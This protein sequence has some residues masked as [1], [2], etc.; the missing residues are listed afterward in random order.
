MSQIN[1]LAKANIEDIDRMVFEKFGGVEKFSRMYPSVHYLNVDQLRTIR[2]D[3]ARTTKPKSPDESKA[4]LEQMG[5]NVERLS[6]KNRAE[7]IG[8][9]LAETVMS[10]RVEFQPFEIPFIKIQIPLMKIELERRKRELEY[11]DKVKI[12]DKTNIHQIESKSNKNDIIEPTIYKTES[13]KNR[14]VGNN[15]HKGKH[16]HKGRGR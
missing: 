11:N 7:A 14:A 5:E 15:K 8:T 13:K 2:N 3:V 9:R 12:E 16:K 4:R 10:L 1:R 6:G